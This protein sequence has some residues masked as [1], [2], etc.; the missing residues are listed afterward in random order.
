MHPK[1][2]YAERDSLITGV[3]GVW[4]HLH[5]IARL[6]HIAADKG[7]DDGALHHVFGRREALMFISPVALIS[8]AAKVSAK[9]SKLASGSGWPLQCMNNKMKGQEGLLEHGVN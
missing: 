9:A 5:V 8:A 7:V 4:K 1:T 2:P 3:T 6:N